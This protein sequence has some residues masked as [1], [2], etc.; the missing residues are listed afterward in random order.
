MYANWQEEYKRKLVSAEEAVKAVKSGDRVKFGFQRQP[1][2]LTS[3]LAARYQD[4]KN[5]DMLM[6]SP[7]VDDGWL[8]PGKRDTFQVSMEF[9][10]G[11]GM[12]KWTDAKLADYLPVLFTTESKVLRERGSESRPIDVYFGV[13]SPPDPHG[14]CS[15]GANLWDRRTCARA[16]HIVIFEVDHS[17]IRTFGD[18]SIHVSEVDHSWN[19]RPQPF[20]G[21]ISIK[22]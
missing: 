14:F 17:V 13:V 2:L 21:K 5:V 9:F 22:C 16:A 15:F 1:T 7:R 3:A 20:P 6:E 10:I 11:P 12:R 18:N 19:I 4:L 8:D